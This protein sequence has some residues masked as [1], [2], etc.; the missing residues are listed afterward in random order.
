MSS[1]ARHDRPRGA[2][3]IA[4]GA[5]AA[6][7]LTLSMLVLSSQQE[8]DAELQLE[9]ENEAVA[10]AP[11]ALR[12]R[13]YAGLSRIEGPSLVAAP[14]KVE[15][16]SADGTLLAR[17]W[18]R[19]GLGPSLEGALV[20]PATLRGRATLRAV[21][22]LGERRE[23]RPTVERELRAAAALHS[24]TTPS[25]R[26][27]APL[28]RFAVGPLRTSG[29]APA[30]NALRVR[31]RG[32][33]CAPEAPCELLVH[34]GEPAASLE[35]RSTASVTPDEASAQPGR[36]TAGV[37]A[38]RLV[39]HGPEAVTELA[40]TRA[41]L[42][43]GS[44]AL[45]LPVALGTARALAPQGLS[46]EG[47]HLHIALSSADRDCIADV[48]RDGRLHDTLTLHECATGA[49]LPRALAPGATRVQLRRDPF[50]SEHAAV[51]SVYARAAGESDAAA[52]AGLAA[53]ALRLDPS[54]AAQRP[55]PRPR[56]NNAS[57]SNART[58]WPRA[59][60]SRCSTK[61]CSRRRAPSRACRARSSSWPRFAHSTASSAS[62]CWR[63]ARWRSPRCSRSAASRRRPWRR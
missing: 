20:V 6:A 50:D 44:L 8:L 27:L 18:L 25:P 2:R 37:L 52:L 7:A 4:I 60:C 54:D 57:R 1:G 58:T 46:R 32:G 55:K 14:C 29:D 34:V 35:L 62:W 28:Q 3:A 24:S 21:A 12:A 47:E 9:A 26:A 63:C 15:L 40:V 30:P 49:S 48:F 61:A 11:L 53:I 10:G 41:G 5:P 59:T 22:G 33:V 56:T 45:R 17:S 36:M 38:L 19:A 23:Q 43:V 39:V 16:S 51:V 42:R 13:L 31:V